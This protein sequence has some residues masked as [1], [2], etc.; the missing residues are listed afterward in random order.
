MNARTSKTAKASHTVDSARQI[1]VSV[2]QPIR[3]RINGLP[4][5]SKFTAQV[6]IGGS[7]K[8]F[9]AAKSTSKGLV[10][11]PALTFTR[12]DTYVVRAKKG[13]K[14]YYVLASS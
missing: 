4:R 6:K 3:L 13:G 8:S 12:I 5:K 9:G 1:A 2:N 14:F 11:L 7:W 10:T